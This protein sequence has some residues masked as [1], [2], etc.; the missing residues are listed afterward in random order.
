MLRSGLVSPLN[1]HSV[2]SALET[3]ESPGLF[4]RL[5][6]D[7][8]SRAGLEMT[9]RRHVGRV[10]VEEGASYGTATARNLWSFDPI[11]S[12]KQFEIELREMIKIVRAEG[13]R[14]PTW[15]TLNPQQDGFGSWVFDPGI[16]PQIR[17]SYYLFFCMVVW[18]ATLTEKSR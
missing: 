13:I 17:R 3:S 1:G 7:E 15:G 12:L 9:L 16:Y 11:L 2:F 10:R 14:F 4:D 18:V 8:Y 5:I 6:A